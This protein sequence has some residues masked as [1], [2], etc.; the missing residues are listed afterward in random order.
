MR[1]N[2][3]VFQVVKNVWYRLANHVTGLTRMI[4]GC[5]LR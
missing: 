2:P 4:H 5:E 1:T 3:P